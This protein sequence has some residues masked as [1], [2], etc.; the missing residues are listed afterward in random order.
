MP[1]HNYQDYFS[2]V[3]PDFRP[4]PIYLA[5]QQEMVNEE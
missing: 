5:V 2:F 4:R 3:T 1:L